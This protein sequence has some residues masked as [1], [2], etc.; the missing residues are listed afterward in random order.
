MNGAARARLA[1]A[2]VEQVLAADLPWERLSGA[3][4]AVTGAS[5]FLGSHIV[6]TLLGLH[7]AGKVDRPVQVLGIVRNPAKARA[8]FA[9]VPA[10]GALRW[11]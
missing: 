6:R 9:D 10:E 7:P 11:I 3:R 8:R 5:G 4:V 2:D 1:A